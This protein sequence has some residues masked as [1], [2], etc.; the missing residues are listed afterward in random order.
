MPPMP[1]SRCIRKRRWIA[2]AWV[3]LIVALVL[4]CGSRVQ[5]DDRIVQHLTAQPP[6][7][8][9][10]PS[11]DPVDLLARA[12]ALGFTSGQRVSGEVRELSSGR[13]LA[14]VWVIALWEAQSLSGY[15]CIDADTAR[16]DSAG[17]FELTTWRH[18]LRHL[19]SVADQRLRLFVYRPEYEFVRLERREILLRPL[20]DSPAARLAALQLID[21]S[22]LNCP[23]Y[24]PHDG[25]HD[26][27]FH[28][29]LEE[30]A[31]EVQTMPE[32]NAAQQHFLGELRRQLAQT[33]SASH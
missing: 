1:M 4:Q 16:S 27:H 24:S 21:E 5:A 28:P 17:H 7:Q 10:R 29:L 8:A 2:I 6:P 18:T 15:V 30:M 26:A 20:E 33:A 14:D 19:P 31:T 22:A 3:G 11:I 12:N 32:D 13:T 23:P 25:A 9:P